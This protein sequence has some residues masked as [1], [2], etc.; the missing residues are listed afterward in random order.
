[1]QE[2]QPV[3]MGM[4]QK[5]RQIPSNISRAKQQ[6]VRNQN[7]EKARDKILSQ[8]S[9]F[10]VKEAYKTLRT[11]LIFSLPVEGCKKIIVTSSLAAEG[12]ST[13]CLNI[14]ITFAEM[15]AKVLLIDADL[16]RPRLA[17]MLEISSSPGLSN[18][19][20]GLNSLDEVIRETPYKN[21]DCIVAGNIPPNPADILSSENMG[22]MLDELS[23]RYDYIFI[24]TAPVNLVTDTA[25]ISKHVNGV[26][27][28]ALHNSTD[29]ESLKYA[30]NQLNFVGAKIL[31]FV[32]N[33]VVYG[34][35]GK[36]KYGSKKYYRY[37]RRKKWNKASYDKYGQYKGYGG[38][39]PY[40]YG[41]GNGA[42]YGYER[43]YGY[44]EY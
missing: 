2:K 21:L 43:S 13:N 26:V 29:Q 28:I 23:E 16:R 35:G 1:M 15:D 33:G 31:G 4:L 30:I 5:I 41:Y 10:N 32:L 22:K 24:D 38:K 17:K 40:G 42:G 25:V 37:G 44:T 39:A 6:K 20:V 3:K 14:A 12:K 36:Y 7:K 27:M 18:F 34:S 9:S 11:N 8:T 19:L